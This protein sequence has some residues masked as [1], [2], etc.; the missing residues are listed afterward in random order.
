MRCNYCMSETM[1]FLP[2]AEILSLEE[3]AALATHLVARGIKRIRLTGGE[4]LVRRGIV[5]LAAN[6]GALLGTE[7]GLQELTLTTNAAHLAK[8][9]QGL[10]QAGVRRLNISLDTLDA[11]NFANIT[12]IGALA[13]VLEGIAAARALGF[14]IRINMV[15][16]NGL[17]GE[18]IP[19]MLLWCAEMGFDLALIET[20]PLGEDM[21]L[22]QNRFLPLTEVM[23]GLEASFPLTPIAHRTSGPARYY[24]LGETRTRLGLISPLTQNFCAS[25]NRVRISATGKLY[26]CLGHDA[27]VDLKPALRAGDWQTLDVLLN[28]ALGTKP[29]A[30]DFD[31][32]RAATL[33]HMSVTGG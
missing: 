3:M 2:K 26:M 20:M 30:H 22:R 14:K 27:H 33:R 9:A 16:L 5:G 6:I 15:A 24:Q 25:C 18:E 21:E 28:K 13:P 31:L 1:E 4:P 10:W 11:K 17:N 8:H 7:H 29:E 19:D 12:R 23:R 32:S